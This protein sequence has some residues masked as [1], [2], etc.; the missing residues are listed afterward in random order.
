MKTTWKRKSCTG[1]WA[2]WRYTGI[3][4][5]LRGMVVLQEHGKRS[6]SV[7]CLHRFFNLRCYILILHHY[8]VIPFQYKFIY[9]AGIQIIKVS[10]E[11]IL[12]L[13]GQKPACCWDHLSP[14]VLSR[15]LYL[16]SHYFL[17]VPFPKDIQL[18]S[19]MARAFSTLALAW[20]NMLPQDQGAYPTSSTGPVPWSSSTRLFV[21]LVDFKQA[22]PPLLPSFDHHL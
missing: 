2:A 3:K 9:I 4:D 8:V 16:A 22:W 17:V 15:A 18:A 13:S 14:C 6:S 20:W 5:V 21:E 11:D 12:A 1:P 19:T 7:L 10:D